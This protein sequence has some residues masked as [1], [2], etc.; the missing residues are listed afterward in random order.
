MKQDA[1]DFGATRAEF[2]DVKNIN[3]SQELRKLCEVNYCGKYGSNWMCPPAV[4]PI[5]ELQKIIL[6]YNQGLVFQTVSKLEDSFDFEGMTEAKKFQDKV[7]RDILDSMKNKYKIN[8]IH[9][10]NA[11][12]CD[13]CPKCSYIDGEECRFPQKA[14]ASIEAYGINV[15]DIVK[16]VDIP[17]ING[18]DTVSYVGLILFS[19]K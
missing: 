6:R 4:G 15:S 5:D 13:I 1:L 3:F 16:S 10:L 12:S 8:D 11:G 2:I 17:Y 19:E 9:G 7:F 14:V 18:K